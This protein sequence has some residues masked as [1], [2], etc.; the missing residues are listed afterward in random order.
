[1]TLIRRISTDFLKDI[2]VEKNNNLICIYLSHPCLPC[3]IEFIES[4]GI[5]PLKHRLL[6]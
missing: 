6:F 2:L 1:M 5:A 4:P 3:S